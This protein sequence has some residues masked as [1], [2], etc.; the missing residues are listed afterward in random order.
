MQIFAINIRTGERFE[1]VDMYWFE[2]NYVHTLTGES[3][4]INDY[5]F[6]VVIDGVKV[7]ESI[8]QK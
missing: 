7:W 5:N 6:E 2:E 4:T 3:E 1:I 8:L